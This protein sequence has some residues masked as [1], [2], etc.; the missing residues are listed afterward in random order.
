MTQDATGGHTGTRIGTRIGTRLGDGRIKAIR[1]MLFRFPRGARA[2]APARPRAAHWNAAR[3]EF[4]HIVNAASLAMPHL[5]PYLIRTMAKARPMVSD[6][7]ELVRELNAYVAQETTHHRQHRAFND[8]LAACGYESVPRI[9]AVLAADYGRFGETK[10]LMF[11][12][13]YA[14]GFESMALAIGHMLVED[15]VHLFGGSDPAVASL[16]LWHFVEEIEHKEAAFDVFHAAGGTYGWR[17]YGL[18]FAT[19]HIFLRTGQGY[20]ALLRE[21]GLW[22]D[23]RLRVRLAVLLLRIF[24]KLTPRLLRILSPTYHPRKVADP[25][26]VRAWWAAYGAHPMEMGQ[27]LGDLDTTQLHK[28]EPALRAA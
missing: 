10:S 4:S 6:A 22:G 14:E 2:Q 19:A 23:W 5:E 21:D 26:W 13:A 7:P 18:A 28:P 12:L 15:R 3:P 8:E 24:S 20:R 1:R 17:L 9:E 11:N 25:A 27:A 16:V